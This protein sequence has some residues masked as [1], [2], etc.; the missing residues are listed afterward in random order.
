MDSKGNVITAEL[1]TSK[2]KIIGYYSGEIE[3]IDFKLNKLSFKLK[4]KPQVI[5][6]ILLFEE[7]YCNQRKGAENDQIL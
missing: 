3:V 7:N 1:K 5:R 2:Y 4:L 6:D